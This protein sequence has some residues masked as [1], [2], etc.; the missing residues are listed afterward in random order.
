MMSGTC[1]A[2]REAALMGYRSMAF[3]QFRK[4][5]VSVSWSVSA[6]RAVELFRFA[7]DQPMLGRGF[8]N[9]NLPAVED[10]VL[11]PVTSFCEPEP[12]A[13]E[14]HYELNGAKSFT[15]VETV[16]YRGNYQ[17]RP[18]VSEAMSMSAFKEHLR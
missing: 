10:D 12:A 2:A 8:W 18:R 11:L 6:Q 4:P 1:S 14:F 3:S 7:R 16:I 9:I 13:L 15:D 17:A 5:H